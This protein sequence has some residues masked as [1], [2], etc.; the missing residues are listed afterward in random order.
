MDEIRDALWSK[1]IEVDQVKTRLSV[2]FCILSSII[3]MPLCFD[4]GVC[5]ARLFITWH[6][7]KGYHQAAKRQPAHTMLRPGHL[8]AQKGRQPDRQSSWARMETPRQ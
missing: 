2:L 7:H 3:V 1:Y 5:G 8:T 4:A 6:F